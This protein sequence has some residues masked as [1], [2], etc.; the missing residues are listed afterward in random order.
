MV[1]YTEEFARSLRVYLDRHVNLIPSDSV[2]DDSEVEKAKK[3]Q[4]LYGIGVLPDDILD[5]YKYVCY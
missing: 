1:D 2:L 3:L 5:L 4:K